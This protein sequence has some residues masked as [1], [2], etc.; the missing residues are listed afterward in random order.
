MVFLVPLEGMKVM[1]GRSGAGPRAMSLF[2]SP[3]EGFSNA[4]RE[5]QVLIL[6]EFKANR[7]GSSESI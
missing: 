2:Y 5:K 1:S 4:T 3:K 6:H 7:Q